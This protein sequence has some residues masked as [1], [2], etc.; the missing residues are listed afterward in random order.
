MNLIEYD[1]AGAFNLLQNCLEVKPDDRVLL[2]CEDPKFGWYDNEISTLL[3]SAVQDL[4]AEASTIRVGTPDDDLPE[5]YE[6]LLSQHDTIIYL[7]RIGDQD[8]FTDNLPGKSVA[9]LYTRDVAALSST[10]ASVNHKAMKEFKAAVDRVS[11]GAR[12]IT[13]ACP[14]GTELICPLDDQDLEPDGEVAIRRFPL[15]VPQPIL[16]RRM[17]GKVALTR[18]LT[19]TGSQ[20]YAPASCKIEGIVFALVEQG[21]IVGFEGEGSSVVAIEAHYEMVSRR[22]GIDKYA[23]HSWHAGIHPA[24]FYTGG[25]DDNPDRW[26]NNIFGSPRFA[27][28]HTCG[29]YPPGEI[30]WMVLDPTIKIDGTPLWEDGRLLDQNFEPTANVVLKRPELQELVSHPRPTVGLDS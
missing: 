6:Q 11:F 18:W 29:G 7:A 23:I 24:C 26:S 13:V 2:V 19:P 20:S 3:A 16:A 4:G 9:M 1:K 30:C 15:C 27:H 28:F 22:F 12:E 14:L 17:S 8:R 21:R 10:Y 5:D 25:I